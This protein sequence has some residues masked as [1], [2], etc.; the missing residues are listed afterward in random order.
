MTNTH[1]SVVAGIRT[2]LTCA[3]CFSTLKTFAARSTRLTPL[4]LSTASFAKPLKSA[5]YS[6]RMILRRRLFTWRFVLLRGDELLI[7][8]PRLYE[9]RASQLHSLARD[10]TVQR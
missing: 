3:P 7:A 1:R 4:N 6:R 9:N 10:A 8:A 2:G 5:N